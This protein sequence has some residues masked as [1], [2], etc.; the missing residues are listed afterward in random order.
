MKTLVALIK[1]GN[2]LWEFEALCGKEKQKNKRQKNFA[3]FR[4]L[5]DDNKR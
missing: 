1:S 4:R 3:L 2:L 5:K